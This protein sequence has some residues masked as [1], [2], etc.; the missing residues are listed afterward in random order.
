M[1]APFAV[2]YSNSLMP[3]SSK[4]RGADAFEH[5]YA[6]LYGERWAT[7]KAAL[8]G[9]KNQV[10]RINRFTS[11]TDHPWRSLDDVP[12]RESRCD[13]TNL[14]NYY[15][16]DLAS[17]WAAELL[18]L[19]EHG[20][21]ILDLCAAPGGKSLIL[22]ERMDAT[23]RLTVNELSP[24]RRHRLKQVLRDYVSESTLS[25][26]E[27]KGHDGSRWG[28]HHPE[29]YDSILLDAPCS[30]ERHVLL[31]PKELEQFSPNRSKNLAVRQYALLAAAWQSVKPGGWIV[32][33][34]CSICP[35]ENDDVVEK[36]VKKKGAL[37]SE[38]PAASYDGE[39][40]QHGLLVLPDRTPHGPLFISKI[41]KPAQ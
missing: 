30:S 1:L 9:P 2:T 19:P 35:R 26:I 8:L 13:A 34:T 21:E 10:A 40:T 27:V 12:D 23:A 15:I 11:E 36:L 29:R 25:R 33:S 22:A 32:Y 31:K 39:K 37:V 5:Y 17:C 16:M 4:K 3:K 28:L 38:I 6:E 7:L 20:G 41:Q 14:R 18:P 24:Q